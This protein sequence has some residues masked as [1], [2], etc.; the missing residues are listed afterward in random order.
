MIGDAKQSEFCACLSAILLPGLLL[1]A[2]LGLW[3]ADPVAALVIAPIIAQ[4]GLDALPVFFFLMKRR[5]LRHGRLTKG[6]HENQNVNGRSH[7][8]T[9]DRCGDGPHHVATDARLP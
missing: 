2:A 1:N 7:H 4:E 9:N 5:A 3:W 8:S 6:Q